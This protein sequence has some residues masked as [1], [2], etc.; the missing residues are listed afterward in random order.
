MKTL[1]MKGVIYVQENIS[2]VKL[3]TL[4]MYNATVEF[5]GQDCIDAETQA[6]HVSQ[7]RAQGS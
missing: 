6:R 5:H 2:P 7:V 3:K 4:E 1:D